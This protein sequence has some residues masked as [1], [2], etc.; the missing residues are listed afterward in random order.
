[1]KEWTVEKILA[2]VTLTVLLVGAISTW[3]V[4][5]SRVAEHEKRIGDLEL[6]AKTRN[7]LLAEKLQKIQVAIDYGNLR[8]DWVMKQLE[9]K[10][11]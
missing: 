9:A 11:R 3:A 2:A 1:M 6:D 7:E 10:K 4:C 8:Q 5:F